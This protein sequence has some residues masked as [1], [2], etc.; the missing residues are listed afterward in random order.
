ML[1]LDK[2]AVSRLTATRKYTDLVTAAN[3]FKLSL[4]N[5]TQ[6]SVSEEKHLLKIH[7]EYNALA[8]EN[9]DVY[10]ALQGSTFSVTIPPEV[11][12]IV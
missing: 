5:A 12:V 3:W 10:V 11:K 9:A 4:A 6:L 1:G 7:D 2:L 8:R